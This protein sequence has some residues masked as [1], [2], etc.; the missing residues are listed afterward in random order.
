VSMAEMCIGGDVG[1]ELDLSAMRLTDLTA[2][3]SES[4][5]RWLVEVDKGREEEFTQRLGVPALRVG[6]VGG[7]ELKVMNDGLVL[8]SNVNELRQRWSSPLWD[9]LG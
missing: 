1:A 6:E 7:D 2:L 5:T 9:L 8:R 3:F 4:N